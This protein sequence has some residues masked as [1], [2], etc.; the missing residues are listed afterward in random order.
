MKYLLLVASL[1]LVVSGAVKGQ[2]ATFDDYA[3]C[4]V[5]GD[6]IE[7]S[8][9]TNPPNATVWVFDGNNVDITLELRD[10]FRLY[11][12]NATG[13]FR[14]GLDGISE[15]SLEALTYTVVIGGSEEY[16]LS[17]RRVAAE[18]SGPQTATLCGGTV[19]LQLT[20]F[21]PTDGSFSG[22]GV[23][24]D[25]LFDPTVAGIGSHEIQYSGTFEGCEYTTTFNIEVTGEPTGD[26]IT[27]V[28]EGYC[29]ED[30]YVSGAVN[31]LGGTLTLNGNG[32]GYD[33]FTGEF[34]IEISSLLAGNY[35]LTYELSGGVCSDE[36][37]FVVNGGSD[38]QITIGAP[39][40]TCVNKQNEVFYVTFLVDG[41]SE[42]PATNGYF[43]DDFATAIDIEQ[44]YFV[45]NTDKEPGE[46]TTTFTFEYNFCTYT[47]SFT[48]IIN[49]IE[50]SPA[51]LVG[52]FVY[53]CQANPVQLNSVP[54]EGGGFALFD[55]ENVQVANSIDETY[56]T[57]ENG[58]FSLDLSILTE[59]DY[60]L[61][62]D[63]G[64]VGCYAAKTFRFVA[65]EFPAFDNVPATVNVG[66]PATIEVSPEGGEL[67]YFAPGVSTP[68]VLTE[69]SFTAPTAGQYVL[70]YTT[71]C[72]SIDY[73]VDVQG[74][75]PAISGLLDAYYNNVTSVTL[76]G[77][78]AGGVFSGNGVTGNIFNPQAAGVGFH[79]ITYGVTVGECS[80]S[81]TRGV[82]VVQTL[83]S[84]APSGLNA[85]NVTGNSATLSWSATTP[86]PGLYQVRYRKVG[87]ATET[88]TNV[89]GAFNSLAISGLEPGATYQFR[90][91]ALCN[92]VFTAFSSVYSF[93]TPLASTCEQPTQISATSLGN[94]MVSVA[95]GQPYD[96]Q[97]QYE[98]EVI[99]PD[100][101]G[102]VVQTTNQNQAI[103]SGIVEPGTYTVNVTA[104][105]ESGVSVNP[106]NAQ[107]TIE[108]QQ[109]CNP[110]AGL[111]SNI[112]GS[113]LTAN[114]TLPS[115]GSQAV[116]VTVEIVGTGLT[117]T[118]SA[119]PATFNISPLTPQTEYTLT[120]YVNCANGL[121]STPVSISFTTPAAIECTTPSISSIA[122]ASSAATIR[123]QR[124][125]NAISYILQ[126]RLSNSQ[127]YTDVSVAQT[128]EPVISKTIT[129]L[130]PATAYAVRVVAVCVGGNSAPSIERRFT[131]LS[132]ARDGVEL[133]FD[134][135]LSALTLYPNPSRGISELSF[136]SAEEGQAT[137]AVYDMRGALVQHLTVSVE[138]G[139][140]QVTLGLCDKPA[141]LYWVKFAK[142]DITQTV[143]LAL[144]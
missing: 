136:V 10:D 15:P 71:G 90:V 96:N 99:F 47:Q 22:L 124:R 93:T 40:F 104:L 142:G 39:Q 128:E 92:G 110:V 44:G 119:S 27:G 57:E 79:V 2:S 32:V 64:E 101:I 102:G 9:V 34:E 16:S 43:S 37:A 133:N 36:A 140:N 74:V 11:K 134:E 62:F 35:T 114:F 88:Q 18:I 12:N 94:G 55:S 130:N 83:C 103:F 77:A 51:D 84:S 131:T 54:F 56:I 20:G 135:P 123:W 81:T 100:G 17:F 7:I 115:S 78:P 76:F 111:T 33:E 72:G 41:E 85:T 95:W 52:G 126:Y 31:P 121:T 59:G 46:Y 29:L 86:A 3:T 138:Q 82:H 66:C 132:G 8:G 26:F 5:D 120:A 38:L 129:G 69:N 144:E 60:R 30:N 23:E 49:P 87:N 25:G 48:L 117:Q 122:I 50:P 127:S 139:E 42:Q 70:R 141:G 28:K 91:R 106:I 68:V 45:L 116:S 53:S 58:I 65:A 14:I 6:I 61:E 108:E 118:V 1:W 107:F 21:S 113:T 19:Q 97:V 24:A 80:Y 143:R 63:G 13:E 112:S 98:V 137:V 73:I 89:S 75:T 105:C 109:P 67:S 4:R 125:P